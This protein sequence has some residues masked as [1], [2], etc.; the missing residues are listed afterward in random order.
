MYRASVAKW[1]LLDATSFRY[2]GGNFEHVNVNADATAINTDA[3][4]IYITGNGAARSN[5][6]LEAPVVD[7]QS[8]TILAISWAV[9]I[10][11]STTAVFESAASSAIFGNTT[12]QVQSMN[13]TAYNGK[14]YESGRAVT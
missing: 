11:P 13:L 14:W 6:T 4:S 5:C 2:I 1:E 12:S 8:L 7:G 10:V 9:T 3:A